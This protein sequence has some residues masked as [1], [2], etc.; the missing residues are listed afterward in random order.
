[1]TLGCG[2]IGRAG[3]IFTVELDDCQCVSELRK[4]VKRKKPN[5]IR[6]D[7]GELELFLAKKDIVRASVDHVKAALGE[8]FI[9][10]LVRVPL[11]QA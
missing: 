8:G 2:V 5:T 1:M 3:N 10:V 11:R 7:A 6:C 4:A 9:H